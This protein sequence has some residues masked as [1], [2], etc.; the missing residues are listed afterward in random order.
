MIAII[1][2]TI[3][4]PHN[5]IEFAKN[6]KKWGHKDI[7]III[8]GDLKSPP[9]VKGIETRLKQEGFQAEYWDVE[10]QLR[11]KHPL[12]SKLAFNSDKRRNIGTLLALRYNAEWAIYLDDDN[13]PTEEDFLSLHT[14]PGKRQCITSSNH[15][16]N[17]GELTPTRSRIFLRGF[18]L[19]RRFEPQS[20]MENAPRTMIANQGLCL[21]TPDIDAMTHLVLGAENTKGTRLKQSVSLEPGTFIPINSQNTAVHRSALPAYYLPNLGRNADIIAGYVFQKVAHSMGDAVSVGSPCTKHIRNKHDFLKD[22]EWEMP[23]FRI[24]EAMLPLLEGEDIEGDSYL[25]C[26]S[27]LLAKLADILPRKVWLDMMSWSEEIA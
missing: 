2:T 13:Y 4:I 15:W 8:I 12:V 10:K 27:N 24:I 16:Y 9:E 25:E 18:P 17:S 3:N 20:I 21:E 1:E 26:Y 23:S 7:A 11:L 6:F 22:M 19:S 14:T 5:L